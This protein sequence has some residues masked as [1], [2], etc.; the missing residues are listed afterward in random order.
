MDA[1]QRKANVR[2]A[3]ILVSVAL[4]F[5]AGFVIKITVLH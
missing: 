2:L 1:Q 3:L 4:V 5:L